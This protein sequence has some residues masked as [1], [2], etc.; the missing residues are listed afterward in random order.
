MPVLPYISEIRLR[1][2][3]NHTQIVSLLL[4]SQ[5]TFVSAALGPVFKRLM[6]QC[7]SKQA[8]MLGA[9]IVALVGSALLAVAPNGNLPF[10]LVITEAR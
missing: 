1:L 6:K 8:W 10:W 2:D 4:L 7:G 3:E 9:F 5:G